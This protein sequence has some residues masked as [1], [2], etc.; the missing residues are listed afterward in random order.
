MALHYLQRRILSSGKNCRTYGLPEPTGDPPLI[1]PAQPV[2]A[3][4]IDDNIVLNP[5]QQHVLP[6]HPTMIN[7]LRN[8]ISSQRKGSNNS[9]K[10]C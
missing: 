7:K 1:V 2:I 5:A 9:N 10:N 6:S 4:T 3:P 8:I